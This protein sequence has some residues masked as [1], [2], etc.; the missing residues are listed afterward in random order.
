MII[1]RLWRLRNGPCVGCRGELATKRVKTIHL[2]LHFMWYRY[3]T[4][5]V[6]RLRRRQLSV[7]GLL[8][9][10]R[11]SFNSA[12]RHASDAQ[13]VKQIAFHE[14]MCAI[15]IV[16]FK[17][18]RYHFLTGVAY[19]YSGG[20]SQMTSPGWSSQSTSSCTSSIFSLSKIEAMIRRSSA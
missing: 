12:Q 20:W 7:K 18:P 8:R 6:L 10:N 11:N 17:L 1:S 5:I 9:T 16:R 2:G 4:H 13:S 19:M 3:Q 15:W 14:I